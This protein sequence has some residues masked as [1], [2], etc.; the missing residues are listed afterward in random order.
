MKK[1]IL[2]IGVLFIGILSYGQNLISAGA[3][4]EKLAGDF[5]FLE[6]PISDAHGDIYF[7]DIPERTIFKW[8]NGRG[9]SV[10]KSDV[11]GCNG[12]F[13]DGDSNLVV[14]GNGEGQNVWKTDI[15]NGSIDILVSD[16][17]GIKFN[18]PNDLW[19]NKKGGIYFTDPRYGE[20]DESLPKLNTQSVYYIHP[21]N[22]KILEVISDYK[23]P[24]GIIGTPNQKTLYVADIIGG[25]VYAYKFKKDGTLKNKTLF[26]SEVCDGMTMDEQGNVYLT[27]SN[28]KVYSP[29]GEKLLEIDVPERPAN[30]CFGGPDRKT[31]YITARTGF[32]AIKMNVAGA[33]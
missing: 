19:I 27:N 12:M 6:G 10:F 21:E 9:V 20:R 1:L 28:V 7:S 18:G 30:V 29:K 14:C 3:K 2:L 11:P 4:V 25:Q 16:L 32:Y 5:G 17:N 31:L 24:N 8:T 23:R 33:Y 26:A 13:F 22:G 15:E